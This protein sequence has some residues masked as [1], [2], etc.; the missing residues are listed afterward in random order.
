MQFIC[1]AFTNELLKEWRQA[2]IFEVVTGKID[3]RKFNYRLSYL[4]FQ[5]LF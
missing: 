2:L 3:V 1:F 5:Y 4:N